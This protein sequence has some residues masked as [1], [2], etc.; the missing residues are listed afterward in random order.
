MRVVIYNIDIQSSPE[1]YNVRVPLSQ[2]VVCIPRLIQYLIVYQIIEAV[3]S[4]GK[5]IMEWVVVDSLAGVIK[6]SL[7]YNDFVTIECF[8]LPKCKQ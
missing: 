1:P 4:I 6:H 7:L 3:I 2:L 5:W 8:T